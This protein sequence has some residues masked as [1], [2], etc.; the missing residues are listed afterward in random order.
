MEM[1]QLTRL[2]VV[3]TTVGLRRLRTDAENFFLRRCCDGLIGLVYFLPQDLCY[4]TYLF[5]T[6][7]LDK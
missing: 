6:D 7:T 1:S 4:E 5:I 3:Q 2:A